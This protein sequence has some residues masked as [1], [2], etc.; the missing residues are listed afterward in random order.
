[1][2]TLP[3]AKRFY[4]QGRGR[5]VQ[6]SEGTFLTC[7]AYG[8][9]RELAWAGTELESVHIEYDYP[10]R[11]DKYKKNIFGDCIDISTR[12]DSYWLHPVGMRDQLTK[13]SLATEEI[14]LFAK[15]KVRERGKSNES[16]APSADGALL[17]LSGFRFWELP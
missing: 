3:N 13:I 8:E 10:Y 14:Y 1:M 4:D 7:T 17:V 9:R 15:E 6:T 5:L 12:D 11:K 2:H 16:N